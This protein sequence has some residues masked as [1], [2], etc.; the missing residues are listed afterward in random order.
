MSSFTAQIAVTSEELIVSPSL[1]SLSLGAPEQSR[2]P[3][4]AIT[5][6]DYEEA[7][8]TLTGRVRFQVANS[9]VHDYSL[10][11]QTSVA[12]LVKAIN[13]AIDGTLESPFGNITGQSPAQTPSHDFSAPDASR[14]VPGLNYVAVDVETANGN[15]GSVCQIGAVKFENG[16][17]IAARSWLCQPPFALSEFAQ[18]NVTI[19]GI[20]ADT[21]KNKP[22]FAAAFSEF[23]AFIGNSPLV[24]H[25][26]KFDS[27]ALRYAALSAHARLPELHFICT[28]ALARKHSRDGKLSF[29][30]HRLPAVA[31]VLGFELNNHHD[32]EAD[33]RAA[34]VI[35]AQL[36]RLSN[37]T[38]TATQLCE[39]SGFT[40]STVTSEHVIPVLA[41][42]DQDSTS[43]AS[44]TGGSAGGGS[45]K[46]SAQS[47]KKQAAAP[48]QKVST[49][50][51]IPD[52]NPD[53]D[54][55]H[56]LFGHNVTLTG[57]FEPFDKGEIWKHIADKGA[58]I[59]KNVTKKTT[60]LVVGAWAKKTSKEKR[61]DQ[62]K[63]QGQNI[64]IWPADK[65]YELLNLHN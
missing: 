5:F 22:E 42:L 21:V 6:L 46:K 23:L 52:T 18:H 58:S 53:A 9:D 63:E 3:V 20:T 62:L 32:A 59:G 50:D 64:E 49:P 28:L 57:D 29:I 12:D 15:W 31:Q 10:A 39:T 2:F 44:S 51:E 47:P 37:F 35:F 14:P 30:N 45:Q 36:A 41:K 61:A 33:A 56:P 1:L 4:S 40:P 7:T 11:P 26:A 25:N 13:S 19:H 17:E 43:A 48:W 38:G 16:L 27:S 54:K 65:L 24:A 34:G 8:D 60:I 55:A